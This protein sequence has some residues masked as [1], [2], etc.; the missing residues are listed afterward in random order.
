MPRKKPSEPSTF[1]AGS[2]TIVLKDVDEDTWFHLLGTLDARIAHFQNRLAEAKRFNEPS[3]VV[4]HY[5]WIIDRHKDIKES[6]R[7]Q[8][9]N[10]Q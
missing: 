3:T 6:M 8:I 7:Q 4:E 1:P 10:P 9:F 5:E 2:R